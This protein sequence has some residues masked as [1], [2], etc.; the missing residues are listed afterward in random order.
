MHRR[1]PLEENSNNREPLELN[2]N[3]REPL[4]DVS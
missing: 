4:I 1:E 2:M 3:N